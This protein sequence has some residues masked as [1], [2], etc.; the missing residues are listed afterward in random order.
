MD[1]A[2]IGVGEGMIDDDF[3]FDVDERIEGEALTWLGDATFGDWWEQV[4]FLGTA[5]EHGFG[6]ESRVVDVALGLNRTLESNEFWDCVCR[7]SLQNGEHWEDEGKELYRHLCN[8]GGISR[9]GVT[10][11]RLLIL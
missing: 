7:K 2:L 8:T 10:P 5:A 3:G 6:V 9:E 1:G 11:H 4:K